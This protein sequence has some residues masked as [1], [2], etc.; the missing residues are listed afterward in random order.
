MHHKSDRVEIEGNIASSIK[1]KG[2]KRKE[3]RGRER[4]K[5]MTLYNI[6]SEKGKVFDDLMGKKAVLQFPDF[7]I[8]T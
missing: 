8:S 1:K 4:K 3:Q 5:S 7:G 6:Q 2:E